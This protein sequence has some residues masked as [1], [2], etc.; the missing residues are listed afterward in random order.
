MAN[1]RGEILRGEVTLG[2][3][4]NVTIPARNASPLL[5]VSLG[6]F[7]VPHPFFLRARFT[8]VD[9]GEPENVFFGR[10]MMK[11]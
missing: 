11:E 7:S 8:N 6:V 4:L 2:K 9:A 5:V 3:L 10:E 1:F